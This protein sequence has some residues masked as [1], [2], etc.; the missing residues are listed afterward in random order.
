MKLK[1][2]IFLRNIL[3]IFVI[4]FAAV[5]IYSACCGDVQRNTT[6]ACPFYNCTWERSDSRCNDESECCP[7]KRC[8]PFGYCEPCS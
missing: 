7:G 1:K 6:C 3:L 4:L 2:L 5:R 8:S